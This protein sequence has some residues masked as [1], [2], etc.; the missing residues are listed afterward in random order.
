MC[1]EIADIVASISVHVEENEFVQGSV[2][3]QDNANDSDMFE[4]GNSATEVRSCNC[5]RR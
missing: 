1:A 2:Q 3:E 4:I 5:S